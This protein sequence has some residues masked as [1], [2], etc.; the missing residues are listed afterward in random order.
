MAKRFT[1]LAQNRKE[2]FNILNRPDYNASHV[3]ESEHDY[4]V[5]AEQKYASILHSLLHI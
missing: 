1:E 4:Q 2:I 3:N 5:Y